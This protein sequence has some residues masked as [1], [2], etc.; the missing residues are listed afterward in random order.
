M[1]ELP[2]P[3]QLAYMVEHASDTLVPQVIACCATCGPLAT[4]FVGLR[5]ISR[6][7][8]GSSIILSDWLIV[9]AWVRVAHDRRCLPCR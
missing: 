2:S 9:V 6:R 1:F 5:F 3:E 4:L 8:T 7:L